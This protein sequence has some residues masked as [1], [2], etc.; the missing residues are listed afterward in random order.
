[1]KAHQ[2]IL[3]PKK[4]I[5]VRTVFPLSDTSKLRIFASS[6][7]KY[8]V[9]WRR[10]HHSTYSITISTVLHTVL[11]IPHWR[12]TAA[13]LFFFVSSFHQLSRSQEIHSKYQ[14]AIFQHDRQLSCQP[15]DEPQGTQNRSHSRITKVK[16]T[17]DLEFAKCDC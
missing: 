10:I 3:S 12:L 17:K 7:T 13:N 8:T 5:C 2:T 14:P 9:A 11:H 4:T 1:M 15:R 6:S 16:A